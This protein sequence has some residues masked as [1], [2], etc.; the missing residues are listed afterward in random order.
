VGQYLPSFA[1]A[2]LGATDYDLVRIPMT[3]AGTRERGV[4]WHFRDVRLLREAQAQQLER[5]RLGALG[6]MANN[7][8]HE[9]NT[10]LASLLSASRFLQ[11][12]APE[13]VSRLADDALSALLISQL[14]VPDGR[15]ARQRSQDRK[16]WVEVLE[17]EGIQPA[18]P[19]GDRLNEA[20][21]RPQR[22]QPPPGW[23][24]AP[25]WAESLTKACEAAAFGMSLW[26]IQESAER[27]GRIISAIQGLEHPVTEGPSE[28]VA[29]EAV[30]SRALSALGSAVGGEP[31]LLDLHHQG[32]IPGNAPRLVQLCFQ[33][34]KNARQAAGATG[35]IR[36]HS[37][38]SEGS[39]VVEVEDDG[40]GIP[41]DLK[42]WIF[43]P[44]FTT[45]KA[46]EG[47]GLGLEIVKLVAKEHGA[48]LSFESRP[49]RTI[50][51]VAFPSV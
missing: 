40:P 11:E 41:D 37:Y 19:W 30:L 46:G 4:I 26:V 39:V 6:R 28:P 20:G 35:T 32:R 3:A 50:F 48:E 36:V 31:P 22:F 44:F 15:S 17:A 14:E 29:L 5:E 45:R 8:A 27:G 7:L 33:L 24:R 21:F 51:R 47:S 23:G 12:K 34:L 2:G 25:R 13:L 10:P 43:S 49:G 38:A 1:E 42:Q 9:L 18:A 16:A